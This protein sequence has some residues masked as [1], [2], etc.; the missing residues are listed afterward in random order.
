MKYLKL[1][2]IAVALI[3]ALIGISAI[4]K[5][6]VKE[7]TSDGKHSEYRSAER[8]LR[9]IEMC[10]SQDLG[11]TAYTNMEYGIKDDRSKRN[12]DANEEESLLDYLF[13]QACQA[14]ETQSKTFCKQSTYP[15]EEEKRLTDLMSYL[16]QKESENPKSEKNAALKRVSTLFKEFDR[17]KRLLQYGSSAEYS[18]PLKTF[19]SAV[20][21]PSVSERTDY[22]K[23]LTFYN[24]CFS[25]S[26]YV[27]DG[28]NNLSRKKSSAER[29]Y[30]ENLEKAVERH[31]IK[32]GV[33]L[34]QLNYEYY[35]FKENS[36]NLTANNRL[37]EFISLQEKNH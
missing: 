36:I 12:L 24:E 29:A 4:Q 17:M 16:Q 30:Y 35:W 14:L 1:I 26:S 3:L 19:N 6:T 34:R 15:K 5:C 20:Y 18:D 21:L 33:D 23:G 2:A 27:T 11:K 13:V 7:E 22:I 37:R 31:H 8:K 9:I 28:I 25:K 10:Q 32:E